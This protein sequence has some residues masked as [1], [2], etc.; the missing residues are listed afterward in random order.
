[1]QNFQFKSVPK[2]HLFLLNSNNLNL[3]K[4]V[5]ALLRIFERRQQK[6]YPDHFKITK[7]K[8]FSTTKIIIENDY[9]PAFSINK[10]STP[11]FTP[12]NAEKLFASYISDWSP[13]TSK[14]FSLLNPDPTPT[15][16][17][18]IPLFLSSEKR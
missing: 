10:D 12:D 15:A 11:L 18:V 14:S 6:R 9:L 13:A 3:Q 8:S 16:T 7:E 4:K 1:M 2:Y 5:I 17:T